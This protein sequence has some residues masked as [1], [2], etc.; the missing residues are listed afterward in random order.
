MSVGV[1]RRPVP[2]PTRTINPLAILEITSPS[3][4][5]VQHHEIS[6]P[7]NNEPNRPVTEAE[8]TL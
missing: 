2:I 6:L 8:V 4:S 3:T 7:K 1:V 5:T